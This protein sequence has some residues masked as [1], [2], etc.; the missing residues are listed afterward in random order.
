MHGISTQPPGQHFPPL[1][2]AHRLHRHVIFPGPALLPASSP[3][4]NSKCPISHLPR[5]PCRRRRRR[6][7][8]A[9]RSTSRSSHPMPKLRFLR[10]PNTTSPA[11][12]CRHA[13]C[14]PRRN[15]IPPPHGSRPMGAPRELE[16]DPLPT[17][18]GDATQTRLRGALDE[19][20]FSRGAAVLVEIL[21]S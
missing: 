8:A 9:E 20:H 7:H 19:F 12:L 14:S 2:R 17:G 13:A 4:N 3:W 15:S 16:P 10:V 1:P 18:R 5:W 21:A 6:R 11:V